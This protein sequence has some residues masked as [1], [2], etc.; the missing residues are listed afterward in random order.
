MNNTHDFWNNKRV[1]ITGHTGF[2]GSWLS[3][4]L[5]SLGAKVHGIALDPP[6]EPNFFSV[7]N[8]G[9]ILVTD[10][11]LDI[12]DL[13]VLCK[14]VNTIKPDIIFHL[15]A[16]AVVNY[17]YD[18]PVET[19]TVNVIGTANILETIRLCDS[20]QAAIMVTTDKCYEN[21]EEKILYKETDRL[22]GTD[23]YS[24]SKA[25]AELVTAAYRASFFSSQRIASAR[26][27]NVIGGGDW[28]S[29]RLIPDCIRAY[30][31]SQPVKLR[32]PDAIRPWQHV[33]ESINGYIML[34]EQLMSN[35]A[36][37]FT[38]AWNFGPDPEEIK[39]VGEVAA[40]VCEILGVKLE[41]PTAIQNKHEAQHLRL[42]SSKAKQFLSWH[43]R[44]NLQQTIAETMSWYQHW[45]KGDDMLNVSLCQIKKFTESV[46]VTTDP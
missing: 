4:W 41:L 30:I 5:N 26:A 9:T 2:K 16:Q 29:D 35:N 38:T 7:A 1:L 33:L 3:L 15:A 37:Q 34:A 21:R 25:C 11:R 14:V 24:S 43:P 40:T 39:S 42:D 18:F 28:A 36:N 32:Y 45:F 17:A 10:T 46:C 8:V 31:A 23:P 20:V 27:G 6:T 12:R 22:V 13:P 19:Y 44:W